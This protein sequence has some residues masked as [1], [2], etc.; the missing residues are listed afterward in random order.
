MSKKNTS[1][2]LRNPK[3]LDLIYTFAIS[4]G[5]LSKDSILQIGNKELFYRMKNNGFIKETQKG[6]N[7]FKATSKLHTLTEKATGISYGN[8]C[9]TKHSAKIGKALTYLPREIITE[10]RFTSGQMLK[11]EMSSFKQSPSYEK[12]IT[13]LQKDILQTGQQIQA[14]YQTQNSYQA[15]IDYKANML[16]Y[17]MKKEVAFSET[18]L[19]I[20]DFHINASRSEAEQILQNMSDQR[21][22]FNE[23][24][25]EFIFL[26]KN[27][28]KLQQMLQTEQTSYQIYFE[29]VTDSYG[30]QEL[31]RHHNYETVFQREVLYIY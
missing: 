5:R 16:L 28:E 23:G 30:R 31:E 7:V 14:T 18:P 22:Q 4:E 8:G 25:K 24:T 10:G 17:Q 15:K 1:L 29:A 13:G 27:V 19:F 2:N 11:K 3:Q 20:P 26:G 21:T 12:A 6:S 9:S